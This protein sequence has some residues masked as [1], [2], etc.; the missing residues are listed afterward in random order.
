MS[1]DEQR[2]KK[3]KKGERKV[4][5]SKMV[6]KAREEDVLPLKDSTD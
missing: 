3:M 1:R 5:K 4:S 2:K 6:K